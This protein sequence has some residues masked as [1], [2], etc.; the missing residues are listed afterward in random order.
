MLVSTINK[1]KFL[2][3]LKETRYLLATLSI[4]CFSLVGYQ[5]FLHLDIF[6]QTLNPNIKLNVQQFLVTSY[7]YFSY[8]IVQLAI[9][10]LLMFVIC[11]FMGKTNA[12][13]KEVVKPRWYWLI[14]LLL[15]PVYTLIYIEIE[16]QTSWVA[17]SVGTVALVLYCFTLLEKKE[18]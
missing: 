9:T 3:E 1:F 13:L 15:A 10:I 6:K 17:V 2:L 5:G 14:G 16:L 7:T 8:L 12:K 4:Y 11:N 18:Q